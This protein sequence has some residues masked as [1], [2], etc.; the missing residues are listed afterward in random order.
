MNNNIIIRKEEEKDYNQTEQMTR[1][2]FWNRYKPGSDEHY[3]VY[4]L[5]SDPSYLPDLS[6]V[7]VLG[8]QVIGCIMYSRAYVLDG[9]KKH[10]VVTFGPLCV[11]PDY[12]GTGIGSR[13][14]R[15]TAKTAADAG[16]PG[17]IIFGEETYYPRLG[18]KTCDHFGITTKDGKNFAAFM[19]YE[20][21]ENTMS[22]VKGAFHIA[23]VY[24]KV[25]KRLVDEFDRKF[26]YMEE[27]ILPGQ[28]D[29]WEI[30]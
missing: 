3:L 28:W 15:E 2:A 10:A 24:G 13:L 11:D 7:A 20:L 14:V 30:E 18:F 16:F 6:R 12:Q 9:D 21:Q 8:D 25:S 1:R 23:E 19:A 22:A 29:Q 27:L 4:N 26:P 17:I 5:R